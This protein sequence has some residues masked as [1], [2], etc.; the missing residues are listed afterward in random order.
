MGYWGDA[1]FVGGYPGTRVFIIQEAFSIGHGEF[2]FFGSKNIT[3]S[4]YNN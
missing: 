3:L 4:I 1:N 2:L